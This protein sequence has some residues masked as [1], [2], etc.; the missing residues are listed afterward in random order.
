MH[1]VRRHTSSSS[2]R[3]RLLSSLMVQLV[4]LAVLGHSVL[5]AA[6]A[7]AVALDHQTHLAPSVQTVVFSATEVTSAHHTGS[8]FSTSDAAFAGGTWS[9]QPDIRFA[10]CLA[11]VE[12][13][14]SSSSVIAET[15]SHGPGPPDEILALFQ[16]LRL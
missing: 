5:M 13:E 1:S 4:L 3:R 2:K 11:T 8:C 14:A 9:H 15:P 6:D 12:L 16:I 10:T 7:H